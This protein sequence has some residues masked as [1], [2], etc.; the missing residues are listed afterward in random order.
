MNLR[1]VSVVEKMK[2]E[3]ALFCIISIS[4][5]GRSGPIWADRVAFSNFLDFSKKKTRWTFCIFFSK[6]VH[7]KGL[8]EKI[9]KNSIF[10]C[11]LGILDIYGRAF[12]IYIYIRYTLHVDGFHRYSRQK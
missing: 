10:F 8:F 7:Q 1:Q 5:L 3:N 11:C 2:I 12:L 9:K 4:D 6:I